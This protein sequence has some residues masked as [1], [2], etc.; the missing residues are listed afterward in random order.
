MQLINGPLEAISVPL[1]CVDVPVK[2]G[3]LLL[4]FVS[5]LTGGGQSTTGLVEL[6]QVRLVTAPPVV[7]PAVLFGPLFPVVLCNVPLRQLSVVPEGGLLGPC[8]E[9]GE[10]RRIRMGGQEGLIGSQDD[11]RPLR[12]F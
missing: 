6:D 1:Q 11:L 8:R 4:Q 10:Q 9:V 2:R 12:P 5:C 3:D 7:L